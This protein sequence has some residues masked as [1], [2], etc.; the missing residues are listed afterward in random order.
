MWSYTWEQCYDATTNHQGFFV[1]NKCPA[2]K[3]L[4]PDQYILLVFEAFKSSSAI[5]CCCCGWVID[6]SGPVSAN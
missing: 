5:I 1:S 4:F 6:V 3:G 2:E